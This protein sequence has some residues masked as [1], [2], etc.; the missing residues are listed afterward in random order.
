[1]L[2]QA[3]ETLGKNDPRKARLVELRFFAGLPMAE[4]AE[5]LGI[6][7]RQAE[8][9]W[10]MTRAWLRAEMARDSDSTEEL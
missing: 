4:T 3:L 10:T 2:E 8:R 5:G 7:L 9:D 6:S 1:M